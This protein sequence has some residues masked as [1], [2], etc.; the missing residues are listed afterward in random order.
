MSKINYI[1]NIPKLI[2]GKIGATTDKA[3]VITLFGRH[4]GLYEHIHMPAK[5]Y[6]TLAADKVLTADDAGTWSL[7]GLV[8]IIPE[9]D[10]PTAP[11]DV[12][13]INVSAMSTNGIY[14]LH[15]YYCDDDAFA[16]PVFTGMT[17]VSRND[18][19]TKRENCMIQGPVIPAGK[20]FAGQIAHSTAALA[21]MAVSVH[22][23]EYTVAT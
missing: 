14:E 17:R 13:W 8:A 5:V 22:Y 9:A 21:T 6:P 18:N 23:H 2:N 12:H 7:G 3:S 15:L 16:N 11:Y 1:D 20:V 10:A 4:T 19:F